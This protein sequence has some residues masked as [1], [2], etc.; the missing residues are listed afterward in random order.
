[1][2]LDSLQLLSEGKNVSEKNRNFFILPNQ[3]VKITENTK[4]MIVGPYH[5]MTSAETVD[6]KAPEVYQFYSIKEIREMILKLQVLTTPKK[7]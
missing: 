4:A 6:G 1:M 5:H 2:Q 3:A 7:I